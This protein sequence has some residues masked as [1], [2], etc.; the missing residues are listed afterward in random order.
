MS[1]ADVLAVDTEFIRTN[2]F[3]PQLALIQISDGNQVWLV[4]FP[5]ISDFSQLKQLFESQS[6]TIILHACAEDLEVL[7]YSLNIVPRSI[8][9]TQIAAG[10]VNRGFSMGYARL[11]EQV[12]NVELDKQST[13]S[14]WLARPLTEKQI[15]YAKEDV[16]YLHRLYDLLLRELVEL[17]RVSWFEEECEAALMSASGRKNS[18]D[19]FRR[20]K[21]GWKLDNISL[22]TL[23]KLCEWRES[24]AKIKDRPRGHIVKDSALLE[25]SKLLPL[26]LRE[27]NGIDG[28][29][30]GQ[31]RR[32]GA[33]IIQVVGAAEEDPSM[34]SLP[35]PLNS[36][37]NDL[38][39]TIRS[40]LSLV[41]EVENIPK[42]FLANKKELEA[43]IRMSGEGPAELPHRLTHGWRARLVESTIERVINSSDKI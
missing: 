13:R 4:D 27:L 5:K 24:K 10:I 38:L 43:I 26:S 30:P 21:G 9:D 39:K 8:F 20:I 31:V 1:Q 34:V 40:A 15:E 33:E 18:D 32:F 3:Y 6:L 11:V 17:D 7:E 22:S 29:H 23:K 37:Q 41:A 25:I 35:K 2:T 36:M 14:N 12:F 19:Y 16:A 42:E 28:L